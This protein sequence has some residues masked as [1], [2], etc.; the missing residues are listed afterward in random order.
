MCDSNKFTKNIQITNI[1]KLF[2]VDLNFQEK[3]LV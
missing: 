3:F 1:F 2:I